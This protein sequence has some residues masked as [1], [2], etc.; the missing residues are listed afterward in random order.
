[1]RPQGRLRLGTALAAMSRQIGLANADVEAI[2]RARDTHAARPMR[3][4]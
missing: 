1:M 3:L 2:E 4:K